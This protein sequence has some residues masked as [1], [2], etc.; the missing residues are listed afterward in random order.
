MSLLLT[1]LT[2]DVHLTCESLF[3]KDFL[4]EGQV[5]FNKYTDLE[6]VR[7]D[8]GFKK[9]GN[10]SVDVGGPIHFQFYSYY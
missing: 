1:Y 6:L 9:W 7:N 5:M 2:P 10:R 3:P 8:L 4:C